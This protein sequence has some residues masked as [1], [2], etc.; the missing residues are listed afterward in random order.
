MHISASQRAIILLC[1]YD[2]TVLHLTL[3]SLSQT[4]DKEEMVVI[5][6]NGKR[7]IRSS[8]VEDVARKWAK[9]NKNRYVVKPLNYG[10]DPYTSIKEVIEDFPPLKEK[11]FICKIDDDLIPLKN[12]WLKHLHKVYLEEEKKAKIGFVTSLINN[13]AWGFAELVK[14]FGKE[15]EYQ[16][17]MNMPSIS[18]T[19]EVKIGEIANGVNGSVWQYPYLAKWCHEWTLL[20]IPNFISKTNNLPTKEIHQETHYSIGCIFF[21]K[22]LWLNI[23]EINNKTN[24]DELSI[25]LYC[26]ENSLK[27]VAVMSEPMGHLYY[28]VQRKANASLLPLFAESL[29]QYW[30]HPSFLEYPKYDLDTQL[31][32]H[33]EELNMSNVLQNFTPPKI[34]EE[35]E[36]LSGFSSYKKALKKLSFAYQN[37]K[38]EETKQ[39]YL[40]VKE[41]FTR[42]F[43]IKGKILLLFDKI[44]G[45]RQLKN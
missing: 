36:I 39:K 13:N 5:V 28:F 21:R 38:S 27:K 2:S 42:K 41:E 19:G 6:L 17:I 44:T 32:M 10:K 45:K 25:H 4:L 9:E 12:N 24:F 7:G 3:E 31:M 35:E 23:E 26:Q 37:N 8:L 16:E 22:N 29:S 33:F 1:S 15:N 30:N 18:G 14:I 20:D 40:S 34:Q 43:P 11:E